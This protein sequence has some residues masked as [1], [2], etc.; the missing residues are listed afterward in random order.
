M[1]HHGKLNRNEGPD[2]LNAR[3]LVDGSIQE[4]DIEFHLKAEDWFHHGH[5]QNPRYEKVIL[6]VLGEESKAVSTLPG[7]KIILEVHSSEDDACSLRNA[8]ENPERVLKNFANTRWSYRVQFYCKKQ[9]RGNE[10]R[11]ILLDSSFRI[12]GKGGNENAFV[13][14]ADSIDVTTGSKLDRQLYSQLQWNVLGMRPHHR[15]KNRV[16]LAE[17]LIFF[18]SEWSSEYYRNPEI[19][20]KK[21][22]RYF[23]EVSGQGIRTELLTNVFFP[24]MGSEA[25]T[26][27]NYSY[28]NHWKTE[29]MGLKLPVSYGKFERRFAHVL[30]EHQLKSVAILQGLK[31]MDLEF[32]TPRHCTVCP[33]KNHG[34]LDE[35]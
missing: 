6:H 16:R 2:A 34:C 20:I 5:H 31:Q 28:L 18:I 13:K 9:N 7:K 33:L 22:A 11:R 23:T 27:G 1:I 32:C 25:V 12:L 19:F 3:L 24:A 21:F 10:W 8:V 14:I 35:N 17:G 26:A 15:P 29:W 4:G 30:S